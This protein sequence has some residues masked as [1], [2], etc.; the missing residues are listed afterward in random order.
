M[1]LSTGLA[2]S[3]EMLTSGIGSI[4][5]FGWNSVSRK[6]KQKETELM[7]S[8]IEEAIFKEYWVA[9]SCFQKQG[10]GGRIHITLYTLS[11]HCT[12]GF[13]LQNGVGVN[14]ES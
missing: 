10:C 11:W 3:P 1:V 7:L 13:L 2:K 14:P 9:K 6:M 8:R 5:R 12:L 4:N